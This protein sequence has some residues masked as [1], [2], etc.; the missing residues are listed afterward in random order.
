MKK[1]ILLGGLIAL[2]SC[3]PYSSA[4]LERKLNSMRKHHGKGYEVKTAYLELGVN[5]VELYRYNKKG[6]AVDSVWFIIDHDTP[7]KIDKNGN[8]RIDLNNY[9]G[10]EFKKIR[11]RLQNPIL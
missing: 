6:K 9:P 11:P 3:S 8:L 5:I 1:L 4:V 2:S 10:L 7:K